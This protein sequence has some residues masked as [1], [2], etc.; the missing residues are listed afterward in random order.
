MT[1]AEEQQL[2]GIETLVGSKYQILG[3]IGGGGMAQV[4]L[5]RHRLHGGLFA[6]KVLAD[7][8]AQ[9]PTIVARFKQE[10]T[11][12]ASLSGHPNIV[13]IFDI[14]EGNG[15]HYLIMQFVCGEDLASF[16]RR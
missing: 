12:A 8:L 6:I 11:T 7:H 14:G 3:R 1:K 16:L 4:L 10:A 13:S 5:A 2:A 15:L 9:D